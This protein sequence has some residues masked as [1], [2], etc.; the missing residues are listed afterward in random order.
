MEPAQTIWLY[1]QHS[2][3]ITGYKQRCQFINVN[4]ATPS[5]QQKNT[6]QTKKNKKKRIKQRTT[7]TTRG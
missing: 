2:G 6:K 7:Q 3:T 1:G 5:A 4:N